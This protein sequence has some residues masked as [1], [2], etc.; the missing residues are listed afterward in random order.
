MN[1]AHRRRPALVED[2][3][4]LAAGIHF[5][6]HAPC[7]VDQPRRLTGRVHVDL[8]VIVLPGND[9]TARRASSKGLIGGTS[10]SRFTPS[11]VPSPA[12]A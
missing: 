2:L 6:Q 12:P 7:D 11:P 3:L 8:L 4:P 10:S 1:V 9:H 5:E